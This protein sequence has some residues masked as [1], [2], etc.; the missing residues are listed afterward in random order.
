MLIKCWTEKWKMNI[1]YFDNNIAFYI[2]VACVLWAKYVFI[3]LLII[4][5]YKLLY[6]YIII[7]YVKLIQA[8][9][10][11]VYIYWYIYNNY[12]YDTYV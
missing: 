4:L 10:K 2:N 6:Y 9:K 8:H 5:Y 11:S 1:Y 12:K 3:Y 7:Y